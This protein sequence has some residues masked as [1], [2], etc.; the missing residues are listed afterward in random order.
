MTQR[1]LLGFL[2]SLFCSYLFT[3][4]ILFFL[5]FLLYQFHLSEQGVRIGITLA[6]L[7]SCFVGGFLTGKTMRQKRLLWGMVFGICYFVVLFLISFLIRHDI[8]QGT[9]DILKVL[10]YCMA[11]G[12]LGAIAS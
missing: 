7:L 6:Y 9:G 5:G 8:Y 11:G 2:R 4:L 12:I 10:L 1:K 3:I